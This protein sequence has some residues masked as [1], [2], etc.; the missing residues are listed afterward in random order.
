MRKRKIMPSRNEHTQLLQ[1]HVLMPH[2][3]RVL[4]LVDAHVRGMTESSPARTASSLGERLAV[5]SSMHAVLGVDRP[6]GSVMPF[7]IR[8]WIPDAMER[9]H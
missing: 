9:C 7:E 8:Q 2:R 6:K 4:P 1:Q 5:K 3:H